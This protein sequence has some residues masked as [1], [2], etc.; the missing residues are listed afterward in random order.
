MSLDIYLV[1]GDV[2]Q[3]ERLRQA[4]RIKMRM[5]KFPLKSSSVE[6]AIVQQ[7]IPDPNVRDFIFSLRTIAPRSKP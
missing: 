2:R 4:K 1:G 7:T 6:A 3:N 5:V